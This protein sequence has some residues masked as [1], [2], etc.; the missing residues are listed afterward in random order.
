MPP[1]GR[2]RVKGSKP[3]LVGDV[4]TACEAWGDPALAPFLA[5]LW[6]LAA[7]AARADARNKT[8]RAVALPALPASLDFSPANDDEV[9]IEIL[10]PVAGGGP[11]PLVELPADLIRALDAVSCDRVAA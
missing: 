6:R 3:K 1:S 9:T 11:A 4:I 2:R 7:E 10:A 5:L 8:R